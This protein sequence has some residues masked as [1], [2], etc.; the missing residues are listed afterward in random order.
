MKQFL[1]VHQLAMQLDTLLH[2][3]CSD[4]FSLGLRGFVAWQFLK[5]A[6]SKLDDWTSTISLFQEE[7]QVPL[8][9]PELAAY[10]GT[11]AEL[12]FSILLLLGLFSRLSAFGL[13]LVNVM[14]VVSYPILW[15]LECPA[16]LNDHF[17]WGMLLLAL[18][19]FGA[20]KLSVDHL[21]TRTYQK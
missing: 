13:L 17:Y 20:G 14:A 6:L 4:I 21:L 8:L 5:A 16:A 15:N 3:Y 18:M 10:V 12:V 2:K 9:S 1:K 7:Y 19:I 11:G